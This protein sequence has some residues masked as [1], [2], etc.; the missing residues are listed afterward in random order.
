MNFKGSFFNI[1]DFESINKSLGKGSFGEV[2]L[3]ENVNDHQLY[4]A[5]IINISN[6]EFDGNSQFLFLQES[7]ILHKLNHPS[8]VKFYGINFK[9]IKD[10]YMLSP[11]IITKYLPNGSL[12]EILDKKKKSL[13]DKDWNSTKK[14]ICLLGIAD[15]MRYLHKHGILHR[16]LKP[17]NILIDADYYPRV[18]DFGL[19]KCFSEIHTKSVKLSMTGKIGTPLYMAPELME[20]GDTC[21]I[22]IDVYAFALIAYEI[23]TGSEPF[24][25]QKGKKINAVNLFQRVMK[26]ERP[27][28]NEFVTEQMKNLISKC[29]SQNPEDRPSFDEIFKLLVDD[30]KSFFQEDVDVEEI[31]NYL[32]LLEEQKDIDVKQ[33]KV[34]QIIESKNQEIHNNKQLIQMQEKTIKCYLEFIKEFGKQVK[35]FESIQF[36]S[37][38][39]QKMTNFL[40]I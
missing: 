26:G 9:S 16:D 35:D 40:N 33:Q 27:E 34:D 15:A 4:A 20:D 18:C 23:V 1:S 39:Y 32:E 10:D 36:D 12:K 8:I 24:S 28:F 17:E 3:V 14:C 30:Y 21:G 25:S 7:E 37:H 31:N 19:S 38:A 11:T 5:K 22:G 13:A 6:E 2:I 29:W